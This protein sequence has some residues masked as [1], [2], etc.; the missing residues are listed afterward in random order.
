MAIAPKFDPQAPVRCPWCR[1]QGKAADALALP[2]EIVRC[3]E[4]GEP[5]EKEEPQMKD[6]K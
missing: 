1:W 2:Y 3:P 5:V 4:C 6:D